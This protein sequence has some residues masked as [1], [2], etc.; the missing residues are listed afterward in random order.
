LIHT[1]SGYIDVPDVDSYVALTKTYLFGEPIVNGEK[2]GIPFSYWESNLDVRARYF[3]AAYGNVTNDGIT[4]NVIT[5]TI[6]FGGDAKE[7][8]TILHEGY[9][10]VK[11]SD[12]VTTA[13]RRD[14]ISYFVVS[15]F[16]E[17]I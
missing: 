2:V 5:Q 8:T 12:D 4:I 15:A 17:K 16:F 10:F 13:T 6:H 11:W 14:K 1:N 3:A 9:R 7:V